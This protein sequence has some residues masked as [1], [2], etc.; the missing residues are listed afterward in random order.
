LNYWVILDDEKIKEDRPLMP[1]T[2][3][4]IAA[5]AALLT[6]AALA[7]MLVRLSRGGLCPGRRS[8]GPLPPERYRP[9]PRLLDEADF[10]FLRAQPG[11]RPAIARRLASRRR[12]VFAGYIQQLERD[13][14]ALHR[15][16]RLVALYAPVDRPDLS[17]VLLEQRLVFA[18][19]ML[20]LRLRLYVPGLSV[21]GADLSRLLGA[22]ER[23]GGELRSLE[24]ALAAAAAR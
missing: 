15:A 8:S 9:L 4:W 19:N 18:S 20:L 12:A 11:F 7:R 5:G 23:V 22:L 21:R 6:A 16:A 24:P 13:F 17:R 1:D 14:L 2:A 10:K 3:L